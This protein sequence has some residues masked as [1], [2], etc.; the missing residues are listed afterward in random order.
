MLPGDIS[1][2]PGPTSVTHQCSV[3]QKKVAERHRAV[4]CDTCQLWCH[5]KCGRISVKEYKQMINTLDLVWSC[6]ACNCMNNFPQQMGCLPRLI[7]DSQHELEAQH[8][9]QV[10]RPRPKEMQQRQQPA[11]EEHNE[12][13]PTEENELEVLK[14]LKE[15]LNCKGLSI[16]HENVRRLCKH[17]NEVKILL[18][19]TPL[20]VLALTET[21]LNSNISDNEL[22]I[23][24]YSIKRKDRINRESW[25]CNIL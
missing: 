8:Q 15:D 10:N 13:K 21:H 25:M 9:Q 23:D 7:R 4:S 2:N 1:E 19:N 6:P 17:L 16:G 11:P 5:I 12:A 14:A 3:S 22:R 20:D 18:E 24:G